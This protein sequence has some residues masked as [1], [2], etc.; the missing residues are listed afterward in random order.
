MQYLIYLDRGLRSGPC[1][2]FFSSTKKMGEARS[3][4][5]SPQRIAS[6]SYPAFVASHE[7]GQYSLV[8][9]T[10][11]IGRPTASSELFFSE[12]SPYPLPPGGL[13]ATGWFE[14]FAV[15][16]LPLLSARTLFPLADPFENCPILVMVIP[17]SLDAPAT[18]PHC[19]EQHGGVKG[20]VRKVSVTHT[21][22]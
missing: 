8:C 20:G 18:I 21:K 13:M 6:V 5:I 14:A 17:T 2:Y 19:R 16:S 3:W 7:V 1:W 10:N 9:A 4:A 22:I 15:P 11:P 12:I